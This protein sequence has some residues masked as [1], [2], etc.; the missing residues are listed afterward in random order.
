MKAARS[1]TANGRMGV[2]ANATRWHNRIAQGFFSPGYDNEFGCALKA[3]PNKIPSVPV[4][5][6]T[7]QDLSAICGEVT[8]A[9]YE[10]PFRSPLQ[11]ESLSK[12]DPG[13]K[14]WAI[15]LCH[16]VAIRYHRFA[17]SLLAPSS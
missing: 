1:E 12:P 9:A 8:H 4:A 2:W 10:S 11:G 7:I 15:L 3:R 6:V 14:P 13:L 16:F 5:S 17:V